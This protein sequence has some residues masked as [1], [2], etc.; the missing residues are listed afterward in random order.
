MVISMLT[1]AF[2]VLI[3]G[4]CGATSAP[5]PSGDKPSSAS[6]ECLFDG[7]DDPA[8]SYNPTTPAP[9][10]GQKATLPTTGQWRS[11][12]ILQGQWERHRFSTVKDSVYIVE[13]VSANPNFDVDLSLSR[14]QDPY[15][16]YWKRSREFPPHC[17]VIVFRSNREGT[18]YVAVV[19]LPAVFAPVN[20]PY[21]IRVRARPNPPVG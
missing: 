9:A 11:D 20:V 17:D 1:G 6:D 18:M 15:N 16:N 12:E 2:S 4:G 3:L 14:D 8:K 10:G 13:L 5:G 7:A 19:A 21:E